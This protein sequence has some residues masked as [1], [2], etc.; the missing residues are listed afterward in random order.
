MLLFISIHS[1][2]LCF[3]LNPF[4]CFFFLI[5]QFLF[6]KLA[7]RIL[8]LCFHYVILFDSLRVRIITLLHFFIYLYSH[9]YLRSLHSRVYFPL[10]LSIY[11]S[12]FQICFVFELLIFKS[13]SSFFF[14]LVFSRFIL[15]FVTYFTYFLF[16]LV[17]VYLSFRFVLFF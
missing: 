3:D 4:C 2:F 6:L 17:F 13:F 8:L 12:L 14:L 1:L 11:S 15:A 5:K 7:L 9:F 16:C 10:F